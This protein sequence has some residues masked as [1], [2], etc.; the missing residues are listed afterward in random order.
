MATTAGTSLDQPDSKPARY[1]REHRLR[2]SIWIGAAEGLLTLLGFLPHLAVYVL[3]VVAILWWFTM[4]R[5]Y[6]SP[7][8]RHLTW[9]FAASQAIAV[10][11]PTVL[12]IAKWAAITAIVVAAAIGLFILF[13]ERDKP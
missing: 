2:L 12:H 9:I 4:G 3:A 13:T 1:L 6:T 5:R 8:A 10:L 11:V 7:T